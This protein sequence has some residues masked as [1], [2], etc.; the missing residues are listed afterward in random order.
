MRGSWRTLGLCLLL[1]AGSL[2]ATAQ[3]PGATDGAT[4]AVQG[5]AGA[6]LAD[7]AA[8]PST[9]V[10]AACA[11]PCGYIIPLIDL[12]F[13]EKPV[14]GNPALGGDGEC[15]PL[16]ED[17]GSVTFQGVLRWYWEISQDGTY[18]N[19]PQQ[20]IVVSFSGTGSNPGFLSAAVDPP[21]FTITT[22]DLLSPQNLK[23]DASDP[24]KPRLWFW[25]ERP[26]NVTLTRGGDPQS[27]DLAR[28][29][30]RGGNFEFHL[31]VKSSASSDRYRESFGLETFRFEGDSVLPQDGGS[32]GAPGPAF[33]AV[34]GAVAAV[35]VAL[36][37]RR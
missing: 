4:P 32:A 28:A 25:Y 10:D 3:Q 18:P 26:L 31:K 34:A 11:P 15:I 8:L 16:P 1:V 36:R 7:G 24:A 12:V 35:A 33:L 29:E 2:A 14:C 22:A 19:D 17:G 9:G 23:E 13:P 5:P 30:Q 6:G 37:R 21:E 27:A 20:D